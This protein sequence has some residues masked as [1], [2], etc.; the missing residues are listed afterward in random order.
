MKVVVNTNKAAGLLFARRQ[1]GN[2]PSLTVTESELCDSAAF[3]RRGMLG[4]AFVTSFLASPVQA[5]G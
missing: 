4:A 2:N 1:G 5:V 3:G